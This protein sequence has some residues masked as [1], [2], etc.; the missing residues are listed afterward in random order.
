M[1]SMKAEE[2][3]IKPIAKIINFQDS[4]TS[5]EL[6]TLAPAEAIKMLAQK[7]NTDLNDIDLFEINKAF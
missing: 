4:A 3:N 2:L 6:F 1:N 7:T 5:P